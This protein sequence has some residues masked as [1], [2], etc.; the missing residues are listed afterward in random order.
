MKE[1]LCEKVVEVR[2]KSDRVIAMVLIFK[3]EV[4]TVICA[5]AAQVGRS[6]CEKDQFYNEILCEWNL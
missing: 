1:E 6:N 4:I 2:R 5:Y 3:E